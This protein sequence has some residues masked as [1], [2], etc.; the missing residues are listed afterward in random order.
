VLQFSIP[1][2]PTVIFTIT[3]VNY[4]ANFFSVDPVQAQQAKNWHEV[5]YS[6]F[7]NMKI[8]NVS[9]R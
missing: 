2:T 6:L 8:E 9:Y 1:F 3:V 5:D 7:L 4:D